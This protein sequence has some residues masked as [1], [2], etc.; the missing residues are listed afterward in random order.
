LKV[1]SAA[2]LKAW[3]EY[4]IQHEPVSPIDLMERAAQQC[5]NWLQQFIPSGK[6]YYIF[7]GKGNNGGDGLAIARL[8]AGHGI[9]SEVYILELGKM[10][11]PEFQK[12]LERL[13]TLPVA[14]HYIQL[15]THFPKLPQEAVV[16]D[17]LYGFGLDRPLAGLS[18]ALVQHLNQSNAFVVSI[19]L[20]S[21][22]F[23]D[24][25]SAGNPVIQAAHTLTFETYKPALI[26][27]ENA[28]FIGD[29]HLLPINLHPRFLETL[30]SG[31]EWVDAAHIKSVFKQRNRFANK[32]TFGHALI[33]GG[34]YGK[35]GAMVLTT[36][37]CLRSGA[38]LVTT[39][40]PHCGYTI[41]QTTAPEAMVI[42][43]HNETFLS[44][45]PPHLER[46]TALGIGPGAGTE[47]ET[48][49]MLQFVVRACKKPMVLDADA[50][51]LLAQNPQLLS[52]LF[53]NTILT[54][55]PK[56]FERLFGACKNDFER[57]E[58]ACLKAKEL[59]VVIILKGHHTLIALPDG[60][61][62]FNS[63]G[64]A[65]MAKGGSGDV[66]TGIITSFLAQGYSASDAAVLG[67][68]L[69]GIAGDSAAAAVSKEAMTAGD[70]VAH[71]SK[72][73]MHVNQ[74]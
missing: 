53:K 74:L 66:L 5:V 1:L 67:V 35:I 52:Q 50:L 21:G 31:F 40:V 19:D 38:G 70:I 3:D 42:S 23:P 48:G 10:G 14:L 13:R 57:I 58:K 7:C 49:K 18:A 27:A 64:N 65:G 17:A 20:P 32:G 33:M 11:T 30:K 39:Y 41:L 26:V 9:P 34:S 60:T 54:P 8:L 51:N 28:S 37:A 62:Y 36:T 69:H 45:P 68:Y 22:L 16:I 6:S 44:Q 29:V 46:F 73:F 56:E 61:A 43:D 47:E 71:L 59:K 15:E 72:A 55:H 4:T 12:N 25:A 2:Q 24:E 63:T